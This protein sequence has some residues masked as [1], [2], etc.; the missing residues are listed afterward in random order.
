MRL[1][2][3]AF[4]VLAVAADAPPGPTP[5]G[6]KLIRDHFRAQ[7]AD[8]ADHCL[9]DLT[10]KADWE[11]RRPELRRQFLDMLGLSPL[12]PRTD[13]KAAVTGTVGGPGFVVEKLHFQ[14]VPGL[15]VTAN[16]YRPKAAGKHPAVLYLCG[17]GNVVVGGTS[18]GS[19][20]SYQYHPAWFAA[21]GYVSLVLD[22]LELG[23]IPGEHHGTGRKGRWW[24]QGRGYTPAGVEC[25]NAMRALDY[26]QTRPEVDADRIGVTG[27]SGGGASSWWVAA[28]DDRVKAIV[29]VAGIADLYSHVVDG[30]GPKYPDGLIRGHCDCMYPVNTYRWDFPMVAALCAP[31]PLLLGNSDADDIFPVPGYR[32]L[33]EKVRKVYALYGAA[34]KFELLE[35]KGP[36]KDTPELR[37]GVN[38]WMARWLKNEPNA[39]VDDDL[40]PKFTPQQLKVFN[41]LPEGA[42]NPA[43]D[44]LFVKPATLELPKSQ[45]VTREWWANKK[46]E[47]MRAL[48]E[49]VFRGWPKEGEP[50]K[51]VVSADVTHDGVRL[52]AVDFLSEGTVELRL[53]VET[54]AG[55]GDSTEVM[56]SVLDEEG[57]GKWCRDLGPPFADALLT[58]G[59][60][61]R[62]DFTFS[63][64]RLHMLNY[65]VAF[66]AV[67]PR[68]IGPTRWAADGS[69]YDVDVRR[70]FALV[71]QSLD[72][73]RVW[74]VRRAVTAL[75]GVDELTTAKLTLE[76]KGDVA[77]VTLYAALFETKLFKLYLYR[78]SPAQRDGPTLLR[79]ARYLDTPQAVGLLLPC[80]VT[81]LVSGERPKKEW[82][83]THSLADA[84]GYRLSVIPLPGD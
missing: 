56:L 23:E 81:L 61:E 44:E 48:R 74:D 76:G 16:L 34:D 27:R 43:V 62:N 39:K 66:A 79:A 51:A 32:R 82:D 59:R 69:A 4:A 11:A 84:L 83:W 73:Q 37:A 29:P 67:C 2:L 14:S 17:H 41:R 3:F 46:P 5:R 18:F 1:P 45:A 68:G 63:R 28:A 35:T 38:R 13:L 49:D 75:R 21:H 22:T 8:I 71:G 65:N 58:D 55:A 54:A 30:A 6:E 26:L 57:W 7:A 80:P 53:F 42:V 47:L 36:H 20:V 50:L 15:Y 33:A 25:W 77:G 72:G 40:P 70:K 31:R 60:F 12:P 9:T 78:I 10:T 64:R 24:W 19:K 52:R